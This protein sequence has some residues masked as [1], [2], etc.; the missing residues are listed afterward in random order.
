MVQES[1]SE[2]AVSICLKSYYLVSEGYR[3]I[4]DLLH[5]TNYISP[6]VMVTEH[7]HG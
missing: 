2:I 4:M 5:V 3:Q 1:P 6:F 7:Q